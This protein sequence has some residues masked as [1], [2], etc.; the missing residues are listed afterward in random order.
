M[1]ASSSSVSYFRFLR[2]WASMCLLLGKSLS[3]HSQIILHVFIYA[4]AFCQVLRTSV[5]TAQCKSV[6]PTWAT[7]PQSIQG[8]I[9]ATGEAGATGAAGATGEQR[10]SNGGATGGLRFARLALCLNYPRVYSLHSALHRPYLHR[11][12]VWGDAFDGGC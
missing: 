2:M 7:G 1:A 3:Q 6:S 12:D 5:T 4:C 11:R 8:L 9:G 10:G